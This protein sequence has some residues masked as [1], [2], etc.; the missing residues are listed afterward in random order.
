[1]SKHK[2]RL[3][4]LKHRGK[5]KTQIMK[6]M[7][8]GSNIKVFGRSIHCLS[9]IGE[10]LYIE[11]LE[12]GL[13][14]R[15]ANSSR[16]A[17]AC[18]VFAPS[19]F[20]SYTTW[21]QAQENGTSSEQEEE[22]GLRCRITMKSCLS[23]FKS[24]S[25]LEKTV[26]KCQMHLDLKE[27]RLVFL[28]YCKHGIVKT[29][30]LTY[31]ET[32]SLQ[33][34]YSKN[35]CPNHII[36]H[37]KTLADV[38]SGFQT[39]QEEIS[40][41]VNPQQVTFKNYVED[42]PDP[43]KVV[44]SE[45]FLSPSEFEDYTIG[46]DAEI[47]F[48]LKELRAILTFADAAG[49][50][51][52]LHFES[53]G[54]PVVFAMEL[55][56][57]LEATFVLATLADLPSSQGSSQKKSLHQASQRVLEKQAGSVSSTLSRRH[58][59]DGDKSHRKARSTAINQTSEVEFPN[60]LNM[61]KNNHWNK[62]STSTERRPDRQSHSNVPVRGSSS[63]V[64]PVHSLPKPSNRPSLFPELNQNQVHVQHQ[65]RTHAKQP[66]R[67]QLVNVEESNKP[68]N[69]DQHEANSSHLGDS[70]H[71]SDNEDDDIVPTTPPS[72][73]FKSMFFGP[74]QQKSQSSQPTQA[75]PAAVVLCE[76]TDD[77]DS[78]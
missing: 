6:C 32:E 9:K 34:V 41:T 35:L 62:P 60:D 2:S 12:N 50:P 19:F 17:Y 65:E 1:M 49:L 13:A 39:A 56:Q 15:T 28:L 53:T 23:V 38:V 43:N 22:D 48:C 68:G 4:E 3:V 75:A 7:I 59:G 8:P 21:S 67:T 55:E 20:L 10:D 14:L 70:V 54:K 31:Q 30:N 73:K 63:P 47:T 11:P 26:D 40:L 42:E 44:H 74:S 18:F 77:D 37:S 51:V 76:D 58:T 45:M 16:S 5:S 46:V 27:C 69:N 78:D 36:A 72:K 25:T 52:S 29:Y 57:T 61:Q 66:H 24:L 71:M 64:L 33:A